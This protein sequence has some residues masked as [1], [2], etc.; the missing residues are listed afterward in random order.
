MKKSQSVTVSSHNNT[1]VITTRNNTTLKEKPSYTRKLASKNTQSTINNIEEC[2]SIDCTSTSD[3]D[4]DDDDEI[5]AVPI[6][7]M[8]PVFFKGPILDPVPGPVLDS[9]LDPFLGPLQGG[10]NDWEPMLLVDIREKDHN[11][12]QVK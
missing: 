9:I 11:L 5:I 8:D 1:E 3:D 12:I 7:N 2:L 6:K 4:D 10:L